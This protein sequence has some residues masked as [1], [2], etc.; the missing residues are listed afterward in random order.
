MASPSPT[1][2]LNAS[3]TFHA[4][5]DQLAVMVWADDTE[6]H[7]VFRNRAWLVYCGYSLE[8]AL[9]FG[10]LDAV[11]PEDRNRVRDHR[12]PSPGPRPD[13]MVEYRLRRYDG[14]YRWVR[15]DS[16]PW[17]DDEG[18]RLGTLGTSVDITDLKHLAETASA[19]ERRLSMLIENARAMV[20]RSRVFP[21]RGVDYVAGAVEAITGRTAEEFYAD[22]DLP[23][24]A[25]HPDDAALVPG[26]LEDPAHLDNVTVRW[27]HPDGTIVVAEHR[28]AA[29][30][31]SAGRV[32]AIEGIARDVTHHVENQQKLRDSE[33]QLRQLAARIQ[34][35]R[36]EERAQVARELHDELGQT[37]TAL[38]LEIGR[39]L[40]ALSAA[41][42]TPDVVDRL[43]S[44]IGLS[45][46]GL[47][48]VK[49]IA[50]NLR[51]PTLDHL[52]LG[53]AIHY[54]ALTFKARTGIRCHLRA[55]KTTTALT[56][57]QQ[58]ALFRIFQEALTNI[59]RHAQA[60]AITVS[61]TERPRLFEL[62]IADNGRGI[63]DLQVKNPHSIGLVG[64]RERAA[65]IGGTF[66]IAGRRG[67]GTVITVQL[68][69]RGGPAQGRRTGRTGKGRTGRDDKNPV[70]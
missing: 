68:R 36:E 8:R 54:E 20:Y 60:S 61:L 47:G 2:L 48:I 55:N 40:A 23:R 67:R 3:T 4:L 13:D 24:K 44:L 18:H 9:R 10:W 57:E 50:T 30:F 31:D 63:T 34:A 59:T 37:L 69:L 16:R 14:E 27:V 52:G 29:V 58:T 19:G 26:T 21:G 45:D 35:A 49:R 43:Q 7:A 70:G 1:S 39:T 62:K 56:G 51:P 6:G 53:E 32:I 11:H 65:L 25:V 33:E 17:V 66:R 41:R 64:M 12:V 46:I 38:K 28:R 22:P 42:L 5:A 15:D